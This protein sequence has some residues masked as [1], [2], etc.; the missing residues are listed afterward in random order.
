MRW[1]TRYVFYTAVG[2]A[3]DI[4]CFQIHSNPWIIIPTLQMRLKHKEIPSKVA[5][6]ILVLLQSPAFDSPD[7]K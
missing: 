2:T 1:T 4:I 7:S 3:V 5:Q 6:Q